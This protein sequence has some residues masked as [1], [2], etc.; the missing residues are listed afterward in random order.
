MFP[1]PKQLFQSLSL[2]TD[3]YVGYWP[4]ITRK[5]NG[6]PN[7]KVTNQEGDKISSHRVCALLLQGDTL[8][9]QS[10]D[11]WSVSRGELKTL[12]FY[13]YNLQHTYLAPCVRQK[14]ENQNTHGGYPGAL[15]TLN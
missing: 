8:T 10:V 7:G 12:F 2:L 15:R 1:N 3:P 4:T 14:Y 13:R 11:R 6:V 9:A 5:S